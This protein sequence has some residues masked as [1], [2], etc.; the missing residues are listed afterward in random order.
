MPDP[1]VEATLDI[2]GT[3]NAAEHQVSP[4]AER[5]LGRPPRTYAQWA[6]RHIAAFT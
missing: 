1:V 3:P 4:D 6:A 5:V 2:P